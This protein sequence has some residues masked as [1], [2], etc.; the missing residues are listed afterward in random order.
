MNSMFPCRVSSLRSLVW[1]SVLPKLAIHHCLH[2]GCLIGGPAVHTLVQCIAPYNRGY[3]LFVFIS[4][5]YVMVRKIVH[6]EMMNNCVLLRDE[7]HWPQWYTLHWWIQGG[8]RCS[9]RFS[10]L[11]LWSEFNSLTRKWIFT[12]TFGSLAGKSNRKP[13]M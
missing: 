9:L 10:I 8:V 1:I 4:L 13:S 3:V 12:I 2:K 5:I 11:S 7:F 6:K